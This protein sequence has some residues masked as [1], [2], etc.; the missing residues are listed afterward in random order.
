MV[1]RRWRKFT[2]KG[3]EVLAK[4]IHTATTMELERYES[5]V[6]SLVNC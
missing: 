2:L 3:F 4:K 6:D 5:F 1:E